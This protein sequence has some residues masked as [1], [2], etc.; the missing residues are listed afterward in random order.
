M[1]DFYYLI[2]NDPSRMPF[3]GCALF[4]VDSEG[5]QGQ[6]HETVQEAIDYMTTLYPGEVIEM[7]IKGQHS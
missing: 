2:T 1:K 6:S 3:E 7:D 4:W 5:G